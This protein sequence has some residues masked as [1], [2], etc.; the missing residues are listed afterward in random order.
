MLLLIRPVCPQ[1]FS[2]PTYPKVLV[3]FLSLFLLL[4]VVC[5]L[6]CSDK[7]STSLRGIIIIEEALYSNQ[8]KYKSHTGFSQEVVNSLIE[9]F[10]FMFPLF[11]FD[12][13]TCCSDYIPQRKL[14]MWSVSHWYLPSCQNPT[15]LI[16]CVILLRLGWHK[17]SLTLMVLICCLSKTVL[18]VA[19]LLLFVSFEVFVWCLL[20]WSVWRSPAAESNLCL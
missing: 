11:S 13:E 8:C 4:C 17:Q 15:H 16:T 9:L 2:P 20:R 14:I 7:L 18:N 12:F 10:A 19:L 6:V 3:I 5:F 1:S